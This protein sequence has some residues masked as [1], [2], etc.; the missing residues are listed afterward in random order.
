[1]YHTCSLSCV[2]KSIVGHWN[3]AQH[4][5][6]LCL[7]RS[8]IAGWTLQ[9]EGLIL[10]TTGKPLPRPDASS[11]AAFLYELVGS[12][13]FAPHP[14]NWKHF[15]DWFLELR[16]SKEDSRFVPYVEGLKM[17]EWYLKMTANGT[18]HSMWT[19]WFIYYCNQ[20]AP[21]SLLTVYNNIASLAP[22]L[23]NATCLAVH[24]KEKGL[25]YSGDP[26]RSV[27]P[28]LLRR[29]SD[30]FAIFTKEPRVLTFKE[31]FSN[32]TANSQIVA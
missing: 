31:L 23:G 4:C 17:T 9:S 3:N 1:M 16:A 11:G 8:D 2:T 6:A 7:S 19:M 25:H 27:A 12:W 21:E 26:T 22:E 24:R 32:I 13:A 30:K 14:V 5:V 15:Q 28:F 29:W 18:A 10:A 20:A